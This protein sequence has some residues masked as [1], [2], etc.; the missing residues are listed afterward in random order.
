MVTI[1]RIIVVKTM[2]RC[3]IAM[4]I[5]VLR[6]YVLRFMDDEITVGRLR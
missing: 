4:H 5:R 3:N 2:V 6:S 1:L